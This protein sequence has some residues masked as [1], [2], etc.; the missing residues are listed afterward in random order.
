L[1]RDVELTGVKVSKSKKTKRRVAKPRA[2]TR[3]P[4]QRRVSV[5][6][7]DDTYGELREGL[8]IAG[9]TFERAC[10]RLEALLEG[11]RWKVGGRFDDVNEF[12]DSL[13]LDTLKASAEA[14]KRISVRIKELQPEAS[15]RQIAK[16][17]G[18]DEKTVRIDTAEKSAGGKKNVSP[19][20]SQTRQ[21][22]GNSARLVSGAKA[23]KIIERRETGYEEQRRRAIE[24]TR[25]VELNAAEL[26]R[27][28][29]LYADPP[30]KYENPPMGGSNRS[31]ENRHPTMTLEEI[32]ALPVA[33]I[34][35][36]DAVLFLWATAP[37]LVECMEVVKCWGFLYRTCAVWVKDKFGTGYY[38]RSQHEL[39]LI[40]KRG[41]L[42]APDEENRPSSML[43]ALVREPSQKAGRVLRHA[44]FHVSGHP[45][46]RV[47]QRRRLGPAL[48]DGV[49]Q[50]G[51]RWG[52]LRRARC[53]RSRIAG[54][55]RRAAAR[56]CRRSRSRRA[57]RRRHRAGR[58]CLIRAAQ[59]RRR[60]C[61]TGEHR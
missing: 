35:A 49:G 46:G 12:L 14:R 9:Y 41:E 28:S 26:G 18:V 20:N 15:N 27:F 34:A 31:I 47:I 33:D 2:V 32:C 24:R 17:L 1:K 48:V 16:T 51:F 21:G 30:W 7:T 55:R 6:N 44:G 61:L 13:R 37:K 22:A 25:Q 36:D 45:Q 10:R 11:D 8:H 4:Q 54:E 42:P 58:R 59:R 57:L 23:A 40:A 3:A 5:P 52:A 60:D 19:N 50:S 38:V 43:H 56:R 29:V 39:L 53:R